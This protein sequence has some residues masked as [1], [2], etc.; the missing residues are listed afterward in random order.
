MIQRI[1]SLDDPRIAGYRNLPDRT[2]RGENIFLAEGKLVALRL[3]DSSYPVE[4]VLAADEHADEMAQIVADRAPVFAASEELIQQI[5]GYPFHRGV[6]ALGRRPA[7]T[8]TWAEVLDQFSLTQPLRLAVLPAINQPENLGLIFRSAT[9]LGVD[10]VLLGPQ[11][12]DPLS[13]R[14]IR[15][16]MGGVLHIRWARTEHLVHDLRQLGDRWQVLR[17]AAVVDPEATPLEEFSWP[18]RAA[19]L[20]GN[21]FEGLPPYVERLCD[22][23][24]TI[25]MRHPMDSLNVGVAAGIF[26]YRMCSGKPF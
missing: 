20:L 10:V 1:E 21:E 11:T 12:V 2:L 26:L 22:V 25:P 17:A 8:P 23:R 19:L 14:S 16:S 4:S 13:R 6:L 3:L 7:Q 24:L 5:V 15:L 9:A 18:Q